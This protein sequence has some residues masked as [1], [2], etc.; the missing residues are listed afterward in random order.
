MNQDF[1]HT[2]VLLPQALDCLDI[3]PDGIYVDATL[4]GGGHSRAI[5]DRLGPEGHLYSFDQDS[6]A[7]E[8]AFEDDRFTPVHGNFRFIENYLDFY[9]AAGRVDGILADL[10]VSS[11]HFDDASRGFS[12]RADGPLDMRMNP[13]AARSAA[14]IVATADVDELT[15]IFRLYGEL[16]QARKLAGLIVSRRSVSP[17]TTTA[18]LAELAGA[19]VMR[20]KQKKELAQVFQALRIAVNGEM[21]ALESFLRHTPEVLCPGGRLVVITYHSL[22][23]RMVKNFMRA[24]SIDG[25]EEKDLFGRSSAPM[26]PLFSKPIVPEE[27]E[28]EANPRSRSAK[29]RTAVLSSR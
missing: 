26:V 29:L 3:K 4:G 24:G 28:I 15:R 1:Y 27:A 12:F 16:R 7:I 14:D 6:D 13:S 23:D 22:E 20:D 19:V 8:R 5:L 9:G 18:Q 2:P 10:G 21:E 17:V 25:A 11:H